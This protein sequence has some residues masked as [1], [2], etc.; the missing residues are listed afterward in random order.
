MIR[1][2]FKKIKEVDKK[3]N[4]KE[5]VRSHNQFKIFLFSVVSIL[6]FIAV[7]LIFSISYPFA[8]VWP[9]NITNYILTA[10][11]FPVYLSIEILYRKIIY[12]CLFF[13]TEDSKTIVII[14][15]ALFVQLNLIALTSAWLF[16]PSVILSYFIFLVVILLNTMVYQH[17][18]SF[19]SVVLSSFVLIQ[20]FFS[21]VLSNAFGIGTALDLFVNLHK[22]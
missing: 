6:Y 10:T 20:I 2:H 17:T 21:A 4:L 1:I 22:G 12:P 5:Y 13:L 9:S 8:F 7:Y 18:K 16:F 15:F 14:I 19:N 11:V 3:F